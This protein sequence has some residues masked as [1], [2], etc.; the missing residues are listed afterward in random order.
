MTTS[1]AQSKG[2]LL[3]WTSNLADLADSTDTDLIG[4]TTKAIAS[5]DADYATSRSIEIL[6]PLEKHVVWEADYSGGT[7]TVGTEYG[8]SD[9][10]TVDVTNTTNKVFRVLK[11]DSTRSKVQGYLK[12]NGAY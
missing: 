12:I 5:T 9:S 10:L 1:Q 2:A 6:V 7:P 4:V 3:E 8:I 11:V